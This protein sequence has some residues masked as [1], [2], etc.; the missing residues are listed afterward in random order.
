MRGLLSRDP[1][2]AMKTQAKNFSLHEVRTEILAL[3]GFAVAPIDV[4][5][6][7]RLTHVVTI[8]INRADGR[9]PRGRSASVHCRTF[10]HVPTI[11]GALLAN[12]NFLPI[13]LT[14]IGDVEGSQHIIEARPPWIA[15]TVSKDLVGPVL[16]DKRIV[17]RY[18]IIAC[19]IAGKC[20][21]VDIEPKNLTEQTVNV[22]SAAERI[23]TTAA[24]AERDI[25]IA[26]GPET[27]PT[28]F[29]ICEVR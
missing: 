12:V 15:Q 18:A 3:Q 21:R 27:D 10:I 17:G 20:I 19:G 8:G 5:A 7:D 1:R 13:T 2:A 4:A 22:L 6:R 16:A 25:E 11:V 28:P 9:S 29:M 23:A 24:V 26:V 14:N